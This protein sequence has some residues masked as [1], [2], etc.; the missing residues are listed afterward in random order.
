MDIANIGKSKTRQALYQLYFTNPQSEYYL[1][2]LERIL[3][4]PVS[5][6]R[7]ELIRLEDD[8]L[9]LSR[10]KGN[11]RYYYLNKEY[12]LF[13]EFKS[14]IFKTIGVKGLLKEK[15]A[16]ILGIETSFIY[17]SY[18]KN[19]EN[20]QSDIDVFII[21]D[22]DEKRIIDATR[23]LEEKLKREINYT[24][25]SRSEFNA[26]KRKK[27]SFILEVLKERKEFLIGGANDI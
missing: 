6:I 10:K 11:Q 1:R 7:K 5:M 2:E 8:G 24:L 21:G 14:I 19:M 22:A 3:D 16:A 9:F 27:D 18:A 13:D 23:R 20:P 17:G 25:Y 4:I 15:L 26:K 12:P